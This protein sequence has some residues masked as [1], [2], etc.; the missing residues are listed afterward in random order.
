M[1]HSHENDESHSLHRTPAPAV[2]AASA[3]PKLVAAVDGQFATLAATSL[4]GSVLDGSG[5]PPQLAEVADNKQEWEICD[6]VGKEDV[7]GVP[8]YWIQ[9]SAT[10]VPK[11][12]MGKARALVARFE[13]GLRA[14][15]EQMGE[16]GRG[17]LPPS[18]AGKQAVAGARF[19]GK[20]QQKKGR[21]RAGV[22]L[23]VARSSII[24]H[25]EEVYTTS[26]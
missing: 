26:K 11:F 3:P 20:T 12:E 17:R 15:R 6:I 8:H 14:Q 21:G 5:M 1:H 25:S 22:K 13:A 16:Q 10:L 7:D 18:N 19:I 2:P 9:W 4:I 23:L 24:V